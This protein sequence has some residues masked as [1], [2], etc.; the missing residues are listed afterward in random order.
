MNQPVFVQ[1]VG[2]PIV[3]KDGMKDSWREVSAW[4][5]GQLRARFGDEVQLKYYDLF[6][7]DCPPMPADAQLP[8]ISVNGEVLTSGVK[9]SVPVLRNRIE[10]ILE[11]QTTF[12]T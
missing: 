10:A 7:A 11:K 12:Q 5:A 8:L 4:A 9:I 1:I 3:C 6:D 2:A